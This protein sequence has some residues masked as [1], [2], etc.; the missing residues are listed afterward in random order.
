MNTEQ[1]NLRLDADIVSALERVARAESTDRATTVRRLLEASLRQWEVE[2]A[3]D[4]YRR[5][6]VSLG[7]AAEDAG[8]TQWELQE[9]LRRER[10]AYPLDVEE[11]SSRLLEL[12]VDVEWSGEPTL[13]DLPPQLGGVLLVGINPAPVSVAAGHYYQGQLGRRL[14]RR[15]E[16]LGLLVD[17]VPGREDEGFA[18]AGHGL[19]DLVKRPTRSAAEI[20]RQELEAGVETLRSKIQTWR[21]GLVVF[22]F[23]EPARVLVGPS[24]KPGAGPPLEGVSTFLLTSPYAPRAEAERVDR[25]LLA[26][27]GS[28]PPVAADHEL[29]QPMR[30]SNFER[31]EIRLKQPARRFFPPEKGQVEI[32]L[33][34]N[35][36]VARYDP[37]LGPDRRRSPVLRIGRQRLREAV[38]PNEQ[39]RVTRGLAGVVRLD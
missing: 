30:K 23:K 28:G 36:V 17:P 13:P 11:V 32:L 3:I 18:E 39:L 15:L 4:E 1:I 2:H 14:W 38:Q 25:E 20:N 12:G 33:R 10:V 29:S 7:R 35:R 37:M 8:L 16:R 31:G 22:A 5:G 6:D 21:P 19:T 26:L 24:V 27:L 34:G 9:L